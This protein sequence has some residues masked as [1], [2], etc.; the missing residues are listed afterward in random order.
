MTREALL[1]SESGGAMKKDAVL[2]RE[3][4]GCP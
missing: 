3:L 4:E 1:E 2:D